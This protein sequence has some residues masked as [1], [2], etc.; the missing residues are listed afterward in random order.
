M[1]GICGMLMREG[2]SPEQKKALLLEYHKSSRL[3]KHRGPDRTIDIQLDSPI[4]MNITFHRLAIMDPSTKGDQPFRYEDESRT[5]YVICNGEIYKYK[6]IAKEEGFKLISGSDC[7]VIPHLYKKYGLV[8][9]GYICKRFNSEHAFAIH[10]IDMKTGDYKLILSSDRYGIRPLFTKTDSQ[11]FYYSS[12]LQGLPNLKSLDGKVERFPPRHYG[13]IEKKDGKLGE[14]KYYEYYRVKPDPDEKICNDLEEAKRGIRELLIDA[15]ISRLD[16]DRPMGCLLSGGWDSSR[17]AAIIARHLHKAGKRLRTFSIG[18]K[19]TD[20]LDKPYAEMV[21]KFID[22]DHTHV[23]FTEQEFIEALIHVIRATGTFDITTIRASTGQYLISKWISQNTDIK[24]LFVGDLADEEE[25][26]YSYTK[27]APSSE[28]FH[29]DCIRLIEDVHFFDGLRA[30]RAVSHFGIELRLPFGDHRLID[31]IFRL[32]P[33]LLMPSYNKGIEKYLSR[34]AFAEEK[35]VPHEV[36]YRAKEA[37]SNGMTGKARTWIDI[38][39]EMTDAM[40]SS[41]DLIAGQVK[42]AFHLPP[43]TKEA[44]FYRNIFCEYFGENASVA[45]TIPYFW[46]PKWC[47]DI[48]EPSAHVLPTY[49]EGVH[50]VE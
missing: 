9:M 17:V 24:V 33:K 39:K 27:L 15:V 21:S 29:L 11:G 35:L 46:L 34:L 41:D 2:L 13:V 12:E 30:D 42:Y 28:A 31:F 25:G 50:K 38:I 19:G 40:Y 49:K 20:S 43:P 44:L 18:I 14:M 26:A 3:I 6:D 37:L 4:D 45:K 8:G 10:D 47:G 48:T 36:L 16:A 5:I 22:S 23:E 7:E 32:D 1:C